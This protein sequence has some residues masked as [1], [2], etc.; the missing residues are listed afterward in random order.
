MARD[1][2]PKSARDSKGAPRVKK[3]V[4]QEKPLKRTKKPNDESQSS[5]D[6]DDEGLLKGIQAFGGDESD[7]ALISKSKGKGKSKEDDKEDVSLICCLALFR[8][9]LMLSFSSSRH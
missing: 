6:E 7:L 2:R 8:L 3:S 1:F 5:S 9:A 4:S